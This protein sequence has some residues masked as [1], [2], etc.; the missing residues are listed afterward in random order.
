MYKH[1]GC[2]NSLVGKTVISSC[3]LWNGCQDD[4]SRPCCSRN[5]RSNTEQ[6]FVE[7]IGNR[8]VGWIKKTKSSCCTRG[9][10]ANVLLER[11]QLA[12]EALENEI[13]E[14]MDKDY[15]GSE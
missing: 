6:C 10:D 4:Y 7:S 11:I 15:R 13:P 1:N 9:A 5:I 3:P 8:D 14:A 2:L 12:A